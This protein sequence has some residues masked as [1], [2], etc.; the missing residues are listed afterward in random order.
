MKKKNFIKVHTHS[1]RNK[2][3]IEKSHLCG[4]FY[5]R[6]IFSPNEITEWI[7]ENN[8]II[9]EEILFSTLVEKLINDYHMNGKDA[10]FAVQ[11]S[12]IKQLIKQSPKTL[13]SNNMDFLIQT[14][15]KGDL[16]KFKKEEQNK[17]SQTAVC[18][19]C[20]IDSVIGDASGYII[21]TMFLKELNSYYF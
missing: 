8:N 13:N 18:P 17:S 16:I 20:N 12:N 11:H 1:F 6:Q 3:E 14:I 2:Q 10:L 5:C 19:Y 15:F 4:C 21:D 7:T 9:N